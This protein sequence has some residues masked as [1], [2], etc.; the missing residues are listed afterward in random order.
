MSLD[1]TLGSAML[2]GLNLSLVSF[3]TDL[4]LT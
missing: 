1:L 2:V 4:S 3:D